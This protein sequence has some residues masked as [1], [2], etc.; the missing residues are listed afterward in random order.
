MTASNWTMDEDLS[1]CPVNQEAIRRTNEILY[2]HQQRIYRHTDRLFVVVM[3][4]Q[5]LAGII[6]SLVIAPH[7][8]IGGTPHVHLHV[9][10]AIFLG[11]CISSAPI[12]MALT[13]PGTAST[14]HVIALAQGLW[15]ALLIHLSG[16][17]IETHFHIFGSLAFLAFYRDWRVL[18][19]ASLVMAV[20][21]F[22]RGIWWPLS[23]YG[24]ALESPFRWLEHT[25]WVV[26]EDVF[27]INSCLRGQHELR[28]IC[29]RHAMLELANSQIEARVKQR[30]HQLE[31]AQSKLKAEYAEHKQTQREREQLYADLVSA[32]RQ[33]G[34][35]EV[36]TGVLHNVGNVLNSVNVSANLLVEG[37]QNSRATSLSKASDVITKHRDNLAAF[38]T[39]DRR[40]QH[41]PDLL[42]ELAAKMSADRNTH[43]KELNSLIKNI[44]HVKEIVNMQQSFAHKG[45][46]IEPVDIVAVM[47]DALKINDTGLAR[48]GVAVVCEYM[49]TPLIA[50][51]KHKVLQIL[52]NLI[53]NAKYSLDACSHNN[54]QITLR[55]ATDPL[56]LQVHICDN[57]IG[58]PH[59]NLTKIFAHG[60]TTREDGHGFGLHSSAL[61]AQELGGSLSVHSDGPGCGA[62]LTLRLPIEKETTCPV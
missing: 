20:D 39:S 14:R 55:I 60:F 29:E 8:W 38:L 12:I 6:I 54:K 33:A 45:G 15:S 10:A 48:H 19:T 13:S 43:L 61:A 49:D 44:E 58:I 40:G 30:T 5:W 4:L 32:S 23:V 31:V 46:V 59:E 36:A 47:K 62:K 24:V 56:G 27:L 3:V 51:E 25:A 9:W 22:A 11:G 37:L 16:G 17:R 42:A 18:V 52:V 41:F 35:A 1:V 2:E 57:G 53:S 26:F 21:H 28:V 7:T 34:M 50:T